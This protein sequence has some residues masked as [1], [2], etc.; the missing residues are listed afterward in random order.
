MNKHSSRSHAVCRLFVTK[1][2]RTGRTPGRRDTLSSGRRESVF[3]GRLSD[4]IAEEGEEADAPPNLNKWRRQ[5]VQVISN[6]IESVST[7]AQITK[8]KLTLCGAPY[9]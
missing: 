5:S 7:S 3:S 9:P 4:A 1:S 2:S 8:G 6:L